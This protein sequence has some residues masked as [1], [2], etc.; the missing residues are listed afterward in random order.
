MAILKFNRLHVPH[1]FVGESKERQPDVA[2]AVQSIVQGE[3]VTP[4]E[5]QEVLKRLFAEQTD[6]N[7]QNWL[8]LERWAN[9]QFTVPDSGGGGLPTV[10]AHGKWYADGAW[11]ETASTWTDN[12]SVPAGAQKVIT[13]T[14][15]T[16]VGAGGWVTGTT[17]DANHDRAHLSLP[18]PYAPTLVS[19]FVSLVVTP[20]SGAVLNGIEIETVSGWIPS[21]SPSD[22]WSI[23]TTFP[24]TLGSTPYCM[25]T[26]FSMGWWP[27]PPNGYVCALRIVGSGVHNVGGSPGGGGSFLWLTRY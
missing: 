5:L 1:K 22:Q 13:W 2:G 12:F 24:V 9:Q 27:A 26:H 6:P 25:A 3:T 15:K 10:K 4:F 8:E 17:G 16:A 11:D 21:D 19:V 7:R 23:S 14:P 18:S 20:M